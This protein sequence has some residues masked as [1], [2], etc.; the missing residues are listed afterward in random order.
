VIFVVANF[1]HSAKKHFQKRRIPSKFPFSKERGKKKKIA[2]KKMKKK[3]NFLK[4]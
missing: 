1:S 3:R 2:R 4:N